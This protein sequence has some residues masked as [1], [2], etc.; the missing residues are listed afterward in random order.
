MRTD[1]SYTQRPVAHPQGPVVPPKP[2]SNMDS[3]RNVI[4]QTSLGPQNVDDLGRPA[5]QGKRNHN[6]Y[7]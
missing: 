2:Q 7:S 5:V 4:L 1:R 3:N 6:E